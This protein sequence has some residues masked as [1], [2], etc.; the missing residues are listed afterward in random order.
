MG[1]I[2]SDNLDIIN[3]DDHH[4][5]IKKRAHEELVLP[6]GKFVKEVEYVWPPGGRKRLCLK[7]VMDMEHL[8]ATSII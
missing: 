3:I 7:E 1:A 2:G 8:G 4:L 6:R 5:S